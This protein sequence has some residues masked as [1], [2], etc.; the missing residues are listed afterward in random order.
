[1]KKITKVT[2]TIFLGLIIISSISSCRKDALYNGNDEILNFNMSSNATMINADTLTFDTVFTTLGTITRY[3]RVNNS[4]KNTVSLAIDLKNSGGLN[5]FRI[6]VDGIS[7]RHFK[8][9]IIPPQDYIYIFVEATLGENNASNPL[10]IE[11]VIE[12]SYNDVVQKSYLQAWGQDAY[13]HYDTIYRNSAVVW[14]TDKPHVIVGGSR[15]PGLGVDSFSTL[16]IPPSCKIYV[17][18]GAGLFVDGELYIG[19]AGSQDSVSFQ[20]HRIESLQNGIDFIDNPGLWQGIT[21]FSGAKAEIYNTT[22]NNAIWGI[23]G[24][25]ESSEMSVLAN[26]SG[27]PNILL[28]KVKI[29]NSALNDALFINCKTNATNCLF[30]SAGSNTVAIALGG[31]IQFDDCTIYSSGVSGSDSK[32]S[33]ILSNFLQI[34]NIGGL[35]NLGKADFTNC[36]FYGSNE[37]QLILSKEEQYD[38]NYSFTNCLI[39]STLESEGGFTNCIFNEDP[40]FENTSNENFHLKENSPCINSGIDNGIF[41]DFYFNT[42][43]NFDIG[44]IAY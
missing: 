12:Y 8:D 37:E 42:R 6:N 9:V 34:S 11:D 24:R 17:S 43:T 44:A 40:R 38:F 36:I 5:S 33:L 2:I 31:D 13:F 10:I 1:M 27:R 19:Q 39:K 29:K 32:E 26:N 22:I 20:T 28:D 23:K 15:F 30:Y 4:S 14:Q 16:T 7:G 18:Q 41:E 21:I 25:H 35:N 3:F